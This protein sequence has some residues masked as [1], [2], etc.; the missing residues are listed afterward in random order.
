MQ[1][2]LISTYIESDNKARTIRKTEIVLNLSFS[3]AKS[4]LSMG[5]HFLNLKVG[6][7]WNSLTIEVVESPFLE[8]FKAHLDKILC[9]LL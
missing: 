1:N 8:E 9:N 5:K 4:T 7:H 3:P 6:E 2:K